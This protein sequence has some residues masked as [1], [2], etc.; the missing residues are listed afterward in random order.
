MKLHPSLTE[1]VIVEAVERGMTG[2]DSP[3]FCI[4]CGAEADGCEPDARRY[5]CESC[6]EM[7]GLRRRGTAAD[8]GAVS[9]PANYDTPTPMQKA[10]L[11]YVL[12]HGSIARYQ[13][14]HW[15]KPDRAFGESTAV[16]GS[17]TIEACKRRDWLVAAAGQGGLQEPHRTLILTPHGLRAIKRPNHDDVGGPT[18]SGNESGE[19]NP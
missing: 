18:L 13:G 4:A 5:K 16:F 19:P 11:E 14:G 15:M 1:D 9:G 7:K 3:G 8:G 10:L 2:L 6:G 17:A 12:Q